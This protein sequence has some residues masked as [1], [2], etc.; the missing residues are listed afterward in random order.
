VSGVKG[1][2]TDGSKQMTESRR[3][4]TEVFECGFR[5]AE[6][7]TVRYRISDNWSQKNLKYQRHSIY[8][9][10]FLVFHDTEGRGKNWA[11]KMG[12]I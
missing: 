2:N 6:G 4:M 1:Q 3:Q 12:Q 5:N 9:L 7:Q 10:N 11:I 8:S